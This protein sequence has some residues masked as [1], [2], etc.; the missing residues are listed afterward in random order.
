M[1]AK[2]TLEFGVQKLKWWEKGDKNEHEPEW[3][4]EAALVLSGSANSV[5]WP[6]FGESGYSRAINRVKVND[7]L[8]QAPC[9]LSAE[10][11]A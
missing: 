10:A 9:C 6:P 7:N 8:C 11:G 4:K 3:G 5:R 2:G 1:S